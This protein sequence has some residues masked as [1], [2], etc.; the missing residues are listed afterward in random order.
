[1]LLT[2]AAVTTPPEMAAL[3]VPFLL[4]WAKKVLVVVPVASVVQVL[5][6]SRQRLPSPLAVV[7]TA[8]HYWR[9]LQLLSD[10]LPQWGNPGLG[11]REKP[12]W[13]SPRL[14]T[15]MTQTRR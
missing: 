3:S 1:M 7:A 11:C 15:T 14:S 6:V 10:R 5:V 8:A 9:Q 13:P 4:Q 12:L 2:T